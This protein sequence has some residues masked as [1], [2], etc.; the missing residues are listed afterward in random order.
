MENLAGKFIVEYT[1]YGRKIRGLVLASLVHFVFTGDEIEF[2]PL[3]Y[4]IER[5]GKTFNTFYLDDKIFL[6]EDQLT[7]DEVRRFFEEVGEDMPDMKQIKSNMSMWVEHNI[8]TLN[9]HL[10]KSYP[11]YPSYERAVKGYKEYIS[12][13]EKLIL[14]Y[15]AP[16]Q[17]VQDTPNK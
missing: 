16:K 5:S 12:C 2:G 3:E 1:Q 15:Y 17:E 13:P 8:T 10:I 6:S 9:S 14:G 4:F 7:E 11:K